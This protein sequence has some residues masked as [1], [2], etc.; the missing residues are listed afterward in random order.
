MMFLSYT[1]SNIRPQDDQQPQK[2]ETCNQAALTQLNLGCI[3]SLGCWVVVLKVSDGYEI[4]TGSKAKSGDW[5]Q[6]GVRWHQV[7]RCFYTFFAA[8]LKV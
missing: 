3:G 5:D 4:L 1:P 2:V 8:F 6:L 7:A